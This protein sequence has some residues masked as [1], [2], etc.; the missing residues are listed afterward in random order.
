MEKSMTKLNGKGGLICPLCGSHT[1]IYNTRINY[2]AN[3]R[4]RYHRCT[5]D[6]CPFKSVTIERFSEEEKQ[7]EKEN[8]NQKC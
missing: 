1:T 3:Q 4:I 2:E 8:E 6:S 7:E 5:N